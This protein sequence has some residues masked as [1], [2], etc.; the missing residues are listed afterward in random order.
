MERNTVI[1]ISVSKRWNVM[2]NDRDIHPV[3]GKEET[4]PQCI[5]VSD[6]PLTDDRLNELRAKYNAPELWVEPA[7]VFH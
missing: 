3:T 6:R 2:R 4:V 5:F 1:N 7:G